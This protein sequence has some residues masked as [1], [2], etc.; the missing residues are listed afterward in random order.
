VARAG[1]YRRPTNAR[2]A[3]LVGAPD[4]A[5]DGLAGPADRR[6][7]QRVLEGVVLAEDVAVGALDGADAGEPM[8]TSGTPTTAQVESFAP[9]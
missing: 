5:A 8:L 7:R 6:H 1:Q 9:S 4:D 3:H 2:D